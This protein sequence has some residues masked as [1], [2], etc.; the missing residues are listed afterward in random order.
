MVGYVGVTMFVTTVPIC[1]DKKYGF[2]ISIL[3]VCFGSN[4][5][6]VVFYIIRFSL[7]DF[8]LLHIGY[9]LKFL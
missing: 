1:P 9:H 2:V 8:S 3:V 4:T 5:D 6:I 7:E